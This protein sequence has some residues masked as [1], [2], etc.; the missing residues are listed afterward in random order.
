MQEMFMPFMRY[1]DFSGRSRRMEYWLFG[2]FHSFI[3]VILLSGFIS[4]LFANRGFSGMSSSALNFLTL[5]IFWIMA[6]FIP[7]LA[8]T[9]RRFHDTNRS[10]WF[11][12]I[13]LVPY[14]GGIV[15]LVMML[16]DGTNGPNRYGPDPKG[17]GDYWWEGDD[18][19]PE[20]YREPAY[21]TQSRSSAPIE[22]YTP[23]QGGFGRRAQGFG[24]ATSRSDLAGMSEEEWTRR[25]NTG[26]S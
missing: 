21:T 2:L 23:T 24:R 13:S 26:D 15:F 22:S 10:G 7:M 5:F 1:A 20:G 19:P 16:L 11:Y 6:T 17:R 8:V 3:S 18:G 14:I 25:L 12:F 4:S 9:V